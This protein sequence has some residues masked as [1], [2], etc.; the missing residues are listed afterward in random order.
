[1]TASPFLRING[2][3]EIVGANLPVRRS[4]PHRERRAIGPFVFFDHM[5]PARLGPGE[6]VDVPPHPHIGLATVTFLFDGE[7][8]HRDSLGSELTITPGDINL[9]TAGHGIV[10]S[11][12]SPAQRDGE[13]GIHGLQTWLALPVPVEDGV[14]DFRHYPAATLPVVQ[15]DG[16]TVRVLIGELYGQVSP[17]AVASPTLYAVVDLPAG[18]TLTLPADYA[19]RGVYPVDG[20]LTLDGEPF[21]A[22]ELAV[23][24]EGAVV[25][26]RADAPVRF[27]LF[28]GAPLDGPRAM[29]WNFVASE[30]A[31]IERAAE[32]WE[33]GRR[34]GDVP[35]ETERLP[36]PATRL[37]QG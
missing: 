32:D 21:A 36:L 19:E 17:V 1:M 15:R 23:L 26:A 16:A 22:R 14:S 33:A 30:R 5:G 2:R 34:F 27:A 12:R 4:L 31:L 18:A 13:R 28:G 10:H 25:T 3:D 37:R 9:M 20:S 8:M 11:E 7:L 6:G 29:W 24:P 35:N